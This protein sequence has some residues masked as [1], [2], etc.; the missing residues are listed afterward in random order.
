MGVF[1]AYLRSDYCLDCLDC[2]DYLWFFR[3]FFCGVRWA[4]GVR[5]SLRSHLT[6]TYMLLQNPVERIIISFP[7]SCVVMHTKTN[8]CAKAAKIL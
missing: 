3:G 7:R 1:F 8:L 6:P 2:L 4:V 5:C